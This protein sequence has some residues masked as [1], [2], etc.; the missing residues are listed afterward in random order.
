MADHL[1]TTDR[2]IVIVEEHLLPIAV[3]RRGIEAMARFRE[4]EG[5]WKAVK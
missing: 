4:T 3:P 5:G 2:I 1:S